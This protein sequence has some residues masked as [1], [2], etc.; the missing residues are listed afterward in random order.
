MAEEEQEADEPSSGGSD[1]Q[2]IDAAH[3][4]PQQQDG[5][6]LGAAK[7]QQQQQAG[8][9]GTGFDRLVSRIMR[10]EEAGK[11]AGSSG[12]PPPAPSASSRFRRGLSKGARRLTSGYLR[13]AV[14]ARFGGKG[15]EEE[16]EGSQEGGD[17][18]VPEAGKSGERRWAG[19][20]VVA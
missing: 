18:P 11:A 9:K 2:P 6:S 3:Q 7:Q 13:R 20:L 4:P 19:R 8:S 10:D 5:E 16:G 1:A 17:K 14:S 12:G 15:A